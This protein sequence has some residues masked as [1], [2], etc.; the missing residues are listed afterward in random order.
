MRPEI[1]YH[2]RWRP[3]KLIETSPRYSRPAI[4]PPPAI[5]PPSR[6]RSRRAG[7]A[8]VVRWVRTVRLVEDRHRVLAPSRSGSSPDHGFPLEKNFVPASRVTIGLVN[9]NT[10]ITSMSVVRPSV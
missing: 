2:S 10:T 3:T 4:P 1:V 6:S 9:R 7:R 5:M 8:E